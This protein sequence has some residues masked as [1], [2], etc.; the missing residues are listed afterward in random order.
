MLEI[1][2]R[3]LLRIVRQF[4]VRLSRMPF[5]VELAGSGF[6][7]NSA[8]PPSSPTGLHQPLHY[9]V[10]FPRAPGR[11]RRAR[12]SRTLKTVPG[13][14]VGYDDFCL[15]VSGQNSSYQPKGATA[16]LGSRS[17]QLCPQARSGRAQSLP[18]RPARSSQERVALMLDNVSS[19]D[20]GPRSHLYVARINVSSFGCPIRRGW[21]SVCR[22]G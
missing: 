14:A 13:S 9:R 6:R 10:H 19:A 7:R 21:V 5:C 8:W 3:I 12:P 17:R 11:Q 1:S 16:R 22:A 20:T 18:D 2:K 4:L 15:K